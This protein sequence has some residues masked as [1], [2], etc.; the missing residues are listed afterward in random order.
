LR[1]ADGAKRAAHA[2]AGEYWLDGRPAASRDTN[3]FCRPRGTIQYNYACFNRRIQNKERGGPGFTLA[4]QETT[5]VKSTSRQMG[6]AT[7]RQ[8]ES[9]RVIAELPEDEAR[10]CMN[11]RLSLPLVSRQTTLRLALCQ[12]TVRPRSARPR[13]RIDPQFCGKGLEPYSVLYSHSR[14]AI[15]TKTRT[16]KHRGCGTR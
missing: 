8:R 7:D 5:T 11:H 14:V 13:S 6:R 12:R 3:P 10:S 16:L 2:S 9:L 15:S 1:G 4:S